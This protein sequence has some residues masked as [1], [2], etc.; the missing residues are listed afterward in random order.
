ML[1]TDTNYVHL[2]FMQS[3][4]KKNNNKNHTELI[5]FQ[6]IQHCMASA[7]DL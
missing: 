1:F 6:D 4:K 3:L 7:I 2:K 5:N